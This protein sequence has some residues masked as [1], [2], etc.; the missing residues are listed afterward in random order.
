MKEI[1]SPSKKSVQKESPAEKVIF[2][3]ETV[4]VRIHITDVDILFF[5]E[6]YCLL[7][8]FGELLFL[9]K[10]GHIDFVKVNGILALAGREHRIDGGQNHS[11]DGD[12]ST[13]LFTAF[14]YLLIF[15]GVVR[16]SLFITAA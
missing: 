1:C 13:L 3:G 16:R 12:N 2:Q 8:G 15:Q 7:D 9:K 6:G 11:C 4:K 14:C 5:K 10:F